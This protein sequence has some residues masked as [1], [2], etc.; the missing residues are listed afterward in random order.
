MMDGS[1]GGSARPRMCFTVVWTWD[2]T[3]ALPGFIATPIRENNQVAK[4]FWEFLSGTGGDLGFFTNPLSAAQSSRL[5]PAALRSAA[6]NKKLTT[7][8]HG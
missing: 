1:L 4:R 8:G 5:R 2:G 6:T 7:D 3:A